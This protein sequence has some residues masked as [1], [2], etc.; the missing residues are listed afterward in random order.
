[1]KNNLLK[2]SLKFSITLIGMLTIIQVANAMSH[3]PV[4]P[5]SVQTCN[6]MSIRTCMLPFP[7]NQYTVA[8]SS[9]A[10]GLKVDLKGSLFSKAVEDELPITSNEIYSNKNG[11]SAAAPVLFELSSPYKRASLPADGGDSLIVFNR[12]TGQRE[13][14]R[15]DN[16]RFAENMLRFGYTAT[17]VVEAYPRSRFQYGANYVAV[18][19]KN[20]R[21]KSRLVHGKHYEA[22]PAVK[23][24]IN[25][26][27]SDEVSEVYEDAFDYIVAQGIPADEIIS[28]T[29]FTVIDEHGNNSNFYD[30]VDI[31]EKD[32]HPVRFL[33][34]IHIP[35]GPIAAIVKGQVRLTD[36]RDKEN[37]RVKYRKG[38]QGR[39]NWAGF[40]L[41]IPRAA[42][43]RKV[44]VA[45]YGHGI[46]VSK[47]TAKVVVSEQNAKKGIATI[48]I[49]QPSHGTRA[50]LEQN[51]L[52]R[53]ILDKDLAALSGMVTQAPIDL[54]SLMMAIKTSLADL[55]VVP[56]RTFRD[57]L[58]PSRRVNMADLDT[59]QIIYEGTSLGGVLGSTF[60]STARDLKGGYMHVTGIGLGSMLQETVF[61]YIV[62]I[63]GLLPEST[64]GGDLSL[65]FHAT[66]TEVDFADGINFAHYASEGGYGRLPRPVAFQY[67]I[68]DS[69]VPNRNSEIYA[70]LLDVPIVGQIHDDIPYLRTADSFEDE[71]GY[72]VIQ[73]PTTIPIPL[74][75]SLSVHGSFFNPEAIAQMDN[76]LDVVL[77]QK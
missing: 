24:L 56:R 25:G 46:G 75:N 51:G 60:V 70:E 59:N 54:H 22:A 42:K 77:G 41:D 33:R 34:T 63:L 1:M 31:T 5:E 35:T 4:P 40:V 8:D 67:G 18:I 71:G 74:I 48:Y 6:H 49:D 68:G 10:T 65:F 15:A 76:W 69:I 55:D 20:L 53:L 13:N 21:P 47:E 61:F 43:N 50:I 66:Q 39:D 28:F 17:T 44:P 32:E 52:A 16:I 27:A 62:R 2:T 36:F 64:T 3:V 72:G 9:S 19:T 11:F 45:I 58:F 37:G 38:I 7:S 73:T 57:I 30:L 29:T 26:T 23:A 12:D 14:I